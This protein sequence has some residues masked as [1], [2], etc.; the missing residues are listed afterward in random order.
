MKRIAKRYGT[1][2]IEVIMATLISGIVLAAAMQ[3]SGT[4]IMGDRQALVRAQAEAE[5]QSLMGLI[6]GLRYAESDRD[7]VQNGVDSGEILS[8][9][10]TWDD[11]D[12]C[13]GYEKSFS[14][15]RGPG[16]WRLKVQMVHLDPV[17][18]KTPRPTPTGLKK[19][20]IEI[21]Q[22]NASLLSHTIVRSES[23]ERAMLAGASYS[24]GRATAFNR[25]PVALASATPMAGGTGFT[26]KL[27]AAGSY[28]PEKKT[29]S[30]R[31]FYGSSIV[32]TGPEVSINVSGD[33]SQ[34]EVHEIVLEVIDP[35]GG[36]GRDTVKLITESRED[37][38]GIR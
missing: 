5:A 13:R 23:S 35:Q 31:W 1:S 36:T 32:G 15:A 26:A 11:L 7:S 21:L 3:L 4:G 2:H 25:P 27:S 14:I 22:N 38:G 8:D 10:K 30:Y 34:T 24:S 17:D 33:P 19:V 12:D 29:L 9:A 16:S 28:D 18:L 20:S 37:E 6:L